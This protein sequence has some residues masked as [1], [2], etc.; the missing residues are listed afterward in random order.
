MAKINVD[1]I[2]KEAIF[3][4]YAAKKAEGY[5]QIREAAKKAGIHPASI[6][7]LYEASGKGK[8]T[9]LTVPAINIRILTYDTA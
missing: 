1:A 2:I 8:F 4:S 5:K 7:T 6:Q 3:T 9:G